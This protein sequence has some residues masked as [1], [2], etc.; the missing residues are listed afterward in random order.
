MSTEKT[1][2]GSAATPLLCRDPTVN[3]V[4]EVDGLDG[5]G[6]VALYVKGHPGTTAV[7]LAVE[8]YC[9]RF[10]LDDAGPP[11][12]TWWRKIPNRKD[13]GSVF[14]RAKRGSR[15]AFPVTVCDLRPWTTA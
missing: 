2:T 14:K 1:Q 15:G 9:E 10:D 5:D 4:H 3:D 11:Y 6:L 7:R 12:M 13:G 8:E